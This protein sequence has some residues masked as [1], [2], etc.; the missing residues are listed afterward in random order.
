MV[1]KL[2]GDVDLISQR[3]RMVD[4]QLMPR[5]ITD[6][7][8]LAAMRTVPRH[9]FVEPGDIAYAYAD[10]PL[11]IGSGQTISQ[12]YI[13]ASMTQEL[14]VDRDSRVLEIG[15]GCG[16]QTAVLGEIVRAVYS[17]EIVPEL[18]RQAND[19]LFS[20]GYRNIH[21]MLGDGS[22]GWAQEAPFDGI[23]VT[24]AAPRVPPALLEQLAE[25]ARMVIPVG[26][27]HGPGQDLWLVERTPEGFS[28]KK[29]YGVR[30]VPM[31][32]AV[33]EQ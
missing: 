24:A 9:L 26:P 27:A 4:T 8:V 11:P 20:L 2:P 32:G 29:L 17:I 13:V 14:Q 18:L 28:K 5:G 10:H 7:A 3:M 19:L 16:Y 21:T 33:E 30:F 12:P 6:S 23:L 15:T 1:E 25:G 31:R 22:L